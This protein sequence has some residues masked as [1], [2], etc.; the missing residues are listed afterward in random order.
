MVRS[1]QT[2]C[3]AGTKS[4]IVKAGT[5]KE[6]VSLEIW[7]QS[8]LLQQLTVPCKTLHGAVYSAPAQQQTG[9]GGGGGE[10]GPG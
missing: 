8:R 1:T 2:A 4:L 9:E 3:H 5:D 7:G 6:G 10:T